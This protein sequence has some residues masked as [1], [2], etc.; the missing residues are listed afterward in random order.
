MEKADK[1]MCPFPPFCGKSEILR[2]KEE[3]LLI[4]LVPPLLWSPMLLLN[5]SLIVSSLRDTTWD[6]FSVSQRTPT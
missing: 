1:A 6:A 4:I 3:N 2:S 5:L